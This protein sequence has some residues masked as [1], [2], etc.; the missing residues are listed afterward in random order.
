MTDALKP[1]PFCDEHLV[2]SPV[3]SGIFSHPDN[4]CALQHFAVHEADTDLWNTRASARREGCSD[5]D[6]AAVIREALKVCA[7]ELEAALDFKYPARGRGKRAAQIR[8]YR[9]DMRPVLK[10]RALLTRLGRS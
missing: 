2:P 1:C 7:D 10:A 9:K 6:V 5:E 3:F 8:Q 4:M